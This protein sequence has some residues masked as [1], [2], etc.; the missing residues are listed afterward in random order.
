[1]LSLLLLIIS[2]LPLVAPNNIGT[3]PPTAVSN[4]PTVV[5]SNKN[6]TTSQPTWV[7]SPYFRAGQEAVISTY[8]GSNQYPFR[9]Y[10][11]TY[12]SALPGVP[13]LAYGI[14]GYKGMSCYRG[15]KRLFWGG[16]LRD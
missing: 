15:R 6:Y 3:F 9:A 10:T 12:S 11:F 13:N 14:Q 2:T 5:T 1:M 4:I 7:T 16:V 8:T